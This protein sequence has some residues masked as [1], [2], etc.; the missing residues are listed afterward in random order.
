MPISYVEDYEQVTGQKIPTDDATV[1]TKVITA[2]E[3]EQPQTTVAE[4]A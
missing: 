3:V 2:P 4:T 1:E